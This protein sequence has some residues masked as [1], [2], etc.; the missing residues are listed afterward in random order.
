[1]HMAV[2]AVATTIHTHG[3]NSR[4]HYM[5]TPFSADANTVHAQA[6]AVVATLQPGKR[7]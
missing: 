7:N 2:A 6:L 4:S 3:G 5:Y 1:M